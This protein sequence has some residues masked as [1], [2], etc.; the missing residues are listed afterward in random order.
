MAPDVPDVP[1]APE[2]P[3]P[4]V[5]PDAPDV[6]DVPVAPVPVASVDMGD[7]GV[8]VD[9]SSL[10]VVAPSVGRALSGEDGLGAFSLA[11]RRSGVEGVDT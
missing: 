11:A 3:L 7:S 9:C 1:D 2:V 8:G 6:A 10:M 4:A 5:V